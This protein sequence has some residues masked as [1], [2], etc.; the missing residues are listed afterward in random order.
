L[1]I[2]HA[3]RLAQL[4]Q[5]CEQHH[6]VPQRALRELAREFVNDWGVIVLPLH[7]PQWPLTNKAAE[8]QLRHYVIARRIS[9]GTRTE[10]GSHSIALL[11]SIIDTCRLRRASATDLLAQAIHAVRM[12]LP[13]PA[14]PPIPADLSTPK[15]RVSSCLRVGV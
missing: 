4:R 10:V 8:R 9:Y 2:E 5:L 6:D 14:L 13:T 7:D 1:A 15:C 12:D 3:H 11:A